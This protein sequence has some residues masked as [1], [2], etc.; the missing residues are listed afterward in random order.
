MG[1]VMPETCWAV[2]VRQSN[3]I[4]RLIV[5]SSWVFYLSARKVYFNEI[6]LYIYI[7]IYI[8]R[9]RERERERD[10]YI[11]RTDELHSS[12]TAMI[13]SCRKYI[14]VAHSSLL[15]YTAH[16]LPSRELFNINSTAIA[17]QHRRS[18][19]HASK[20]SYYSSLV[21]PMCSAR[22]IHSFGRKQ[23]FYLQGRMG[24][25]FFSCGMLVHF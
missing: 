2:S 15:G 22:R 9:E 4:L 13:V 25:I 1:I 14:P 23:R 16:L 12:F 19:I 7:Y 24:G 11:W 21:T 3:K 17:K 5:A 18:I 10:I 8:Y 20:Q 6:G